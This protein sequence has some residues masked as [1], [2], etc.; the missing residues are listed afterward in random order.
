M[1]EKLSLSGWL[2][3]IVSLIVG[4]L[5]LQ[6]AYQSQV[7][8]YK[9]M[10]L[11]EWTAKKDFLEMC[12]NMNSSA[13]NVALE[14]NRA[15]R[16]PFPAP[17]GIVFSQS[18]ELSRRTVRDFCESTNE[19]LYDPP[20]HLLDQ[21][22]SSLENA[23]SANW[24]VL[25]FLMFLG[26][27]FILLH[28][29]RRLT[30][31]LYRQYRSPRT[32]YRKLR[33]SQSQHQSDSL[34]PHV[35]I[36][37]QNT[38]TLQNSFASEEP[39][40]SHTLR[41][42]KGGQHVD[43]WTAAERGSVR[44]IQNQIASGVHVDAMNPHG[45]TALIISSRH[46]RLEAVK[47]LLSARAQIN[48]E[49]GIHGSALKAAAAHGHDDVVRTLLNHKELTYPGPCGGAT[50]HALHIAC[51]QGHEPVVKVLIDFGTDINF[52]NSREPSALQIATQEGH[53]AIV[54]LLLQNG[55]FPANNNPGALEIAAQE[56]YEAIA[57][58]ILDPEI[59]H[60]ARDE[61]IGPA[62]LIAAQRKHMSILDFLLSQDSH[63]KASN[64]D[65]V[66][67]LIAAAKGGFK[68]TVTRLLER[69]V[70]IIGRS[71]G[72][73]VMAAAAREGYET[74]V[75]ALLECETE[76]DPP[77][78][79]E[80]VLEAA[81]GGGCKEV[82]LDLLHRG[83]N[84]NAR[85]SLN[86]NALCSAASNGH[87]KIVEILLAHQADPNAQGHCCGNALK[88]AVEGG[89]G[90]IVTLLLLHGAN[91]DAECNF[92]GNTL[93]KAMSNGHA[94][95]IKA[96]LDEGAVL[97]TKEP[98][99]TSPLRGSSSSRFE[100]DVTLAERVKSLSL[101]HSRGLSSPDLSGIEDDSCIE[102]DKGEYLEN[103][104]Y[105][106]DSIFQVDL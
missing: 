55:A 44:E 40:F 104:G 32:P 90:S 50:I 74:I 3:L 53:G 96:L 62:V 11:A 54:K 63:L 73:D 38:S 1:R 9:S 47:T 28:N 83:I 10:K 17:P 102:F 68:R 35:I 7:L 12:L 78:Y 2:G 67:I 106:E 16:I 19:A 42:R 52:N 6:Y 43:L 105:V 86:R 39:I 4:V 87:E 79:Y 60:R 34:Q 84:V 49:G 26:V 101:E 46:G 99:L 85:D 13:S 69:G 88:G 81:A 57:R 56:G 59:N 97:F 103:E 64:E 65:V 30:R 37:A 41:H 75:F 20:V 31:L 77:F 14:C 94:A 95:I 33:N 72:R 100:K 58:L 66:A 24:A 48:S 61:E 25:R 23:K 76:I 45:E 5:A 51:R 8:A 15:L 98:Y 21:M 27:G 80:T 91:V 36:D 82:V 29:R 22:R 93:K 18:N 70:R 89:H 92:C 71:Q